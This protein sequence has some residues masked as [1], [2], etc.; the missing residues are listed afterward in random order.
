MPTHS[1]EIK[2]CIMRVGMTMS[3]SVEIPAD[4]LGCEIEW[5]KRRE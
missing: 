3:E 2:S 5:Q 4:A 1:A